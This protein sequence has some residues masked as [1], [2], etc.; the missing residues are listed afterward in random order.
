MLAWLISVFKT[1]FIKTL[2]CFFQ[3]T[4]FFNKLFSKYF[5]KSSKHIYTWDFINM[6]IRGVIVGLQC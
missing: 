2:N 3:I 1:L 4:F 5:F 6:E